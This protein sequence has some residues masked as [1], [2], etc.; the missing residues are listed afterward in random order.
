MKKN[1]TPTWETNVMKRY[2]LS[3]IAMMA[4]AT[5]LVSCGGEP[6]QTSGEAALDNTQE[7]LDFYAAN[8]DRFRFKTIADLPQDLDWEDGLELSEIGSPNAKKGGT[9]YDVLA[10]FPS[11]LRLNGPDS[12]GSFA[13]WNHEGSS[14]MLADRHPNDLEYYPGVVKEW[15][16][17]EEDNTVYMRIDPDARW[18][19]GE[20]ITSDDML[21]RM[22]YGM[23]EYINDPWENNYWTNEFTHATKFDD[24]T[25]AFGVPKVRLD[26]LA[27]VLEIY[28]VPQHFFKELGSDFAERYQ[29]RPMPTAGA[30]EIKPENIDLG[31]NLVLTKVED[32]W[33]QDKKFWR[34]R[35]NPERINL[36]VV[37]DPAKRFEAFRSGDIDQFAIVTTEYWYEFLSNDDPDVAK[38]YIHKAQF[39]NSGPR[40]NFGL[41]IN[42]GRPLLDNIDVRLGIQYASNWDLVLEKYFRGEL[43]RLN[44]QRDGYGKYSHPTLTARPFDIS[45]AQEHFANAGFTTRGPDGILVNDQGQRLA[46]TLTTDYARFADIFTILKEE[47]A[48][49]GLEYR[50]EILDSGAGFRKAQEKQHDIYFVSFS[51]PLELVPR[52]WDFAH[53]INAYDQA[54]L[55]DGSVNPN[56]KLKSQTNNLE[57]IAVYE[58]DQLI[59]RYN[60]STDEGELVELSHRL[61]EMHH[62][63]ASFVPGQVQPFYWHSNWRWVQ[64]PE[65]FNLQF[66][67][68]AVET[69]VHWIDED[70]KAETL[71]ARN[72][73][74]AFEPHVQVY[75]QYRVQ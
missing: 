1:A 32:W 2:L 4:M 65:D 5:L 67:N 38:G 11:T 52:F 73:G 44:T 13:F 75:D 71:A 41:W 70:M 35:F 66:T 45:K 51:T 29:W 20:P 61:I 42:S 55:E 17:S 10:D 26:T 39:Y 21:F 3:G 27:V 58:M 14:M 33:A 63:Y 6:E 36:S 46:F 23:S 28:P 34:Y 60:R 22:Y 57:S 16:I 12:N 69:M 64:W 19:D 18:S 37:R 74:E 68:S 15:A 25:F 9:A 50:I 47:A 24:L 56:R 54:F 31:T 8:P 48:K 59:D 30:Y 43:Q 40:G 62:D 49:A 72:A 53:S 7:V